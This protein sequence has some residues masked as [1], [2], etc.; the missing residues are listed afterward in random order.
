MEG[1][2]LRVAVLTLTRDRLEYTQYCFE[3]LESLAGC[4]YDHFVYDNGSDDGTVQWLGEWFQG[5]DA[6]HRRGYVLSADNVGVSRGMNG[7]FDRLPRYGMYDVV[8]KF[9]NDCELTVEGTLAA[10]A[11]VAAT[12]GWIVSPQILGLNDPVPIDTDEIVA[13][14]RVGSVPYIGGIFLAA[15]GFLYM[16]EG[17]RHD[18]TNPIW[19]MDDV[20]LGGHWKG[21]GGKLGYLLDYPSNHYETTQGQ[22]ERYPQY[23][24]RKDEEFAA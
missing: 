19:G 17:Y 3:R 11:E 14:Y 10:A 24:K 22:R 20:A 23:F 7:L 21:R 8:V 2:D 9:D 18:E 13:G 12:G 16:E 4:P 6:D 5:G 15:P 1:C